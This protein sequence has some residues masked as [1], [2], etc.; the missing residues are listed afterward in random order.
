MGVLNG[1]MV[2]KENQTDSDR[3]LDGQESNIINYPKVQ[4]SIT[5]DIVIIL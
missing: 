4:G 3:C 5:L 1:G 2:C